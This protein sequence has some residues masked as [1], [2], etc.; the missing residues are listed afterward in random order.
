ML[1][2]FSAWVATRFQ[3]AFPIGQ[4]ISYSM[5]VKFD[6][7][8]PVL[9]GKDGSAAADLDV[10][11]TGLDPDKDGNPQVRSEIVGL[12]MS[13]NGAVL[14]INAKNVQT[15]F[16]PTTISISP[17]GRVLKTDAPAARL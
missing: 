3:Y 7:Y 8:L 1:A 5:S 10:S 13:I 16:P 4:K 17:Q 14:P 12:K 9:G 15:F 6:G 2:V 11:V